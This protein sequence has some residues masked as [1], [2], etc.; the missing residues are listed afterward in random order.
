[1]SYVFGF[2]KLEV[3]QLSKDFVIEVYKLTQNFP[4]CEKY[5]LASQLNRASV[6]IA[7]NLAEGTSRKT[8]K[9]Q[10]NFSQI[11]YSSLM[12][13]MCQLIIAKEIGIMNE[14]DYKILR[15]KAE[16]ISNKINALRNYQLNKK[17]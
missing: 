3:W 1:M 5:G 14:R 13:V 6:S 9:D 7:S 4:D 16:I 11:A 8:S 15:E 10:A 17:S 12:E 2:E